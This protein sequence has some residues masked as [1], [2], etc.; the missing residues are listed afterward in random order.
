MNCL[1]DFLSLQ[2]AVVD[3]FCD[4]SRRELFEFFTS[5]KKS[6]S[7]GKK[8]KIPATISCVNLLFLPTVRQAKAKTAICHR[9]MQPF[10]EYCYRKQHASNSKIV[11]RTILS[12]YH[13]P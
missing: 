5:C 11:L 8:I 6:V 9:T 13:L 3:P 7:G 4:G 1:I 12:Q 10:E 2:S